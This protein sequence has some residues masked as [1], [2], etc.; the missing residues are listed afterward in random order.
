MS[1]EFAQAIPFR[2]SRRGDDGR[3][4]IVGRVFRE[5]QIEVVGELV[6]TPRESP[7]NDAA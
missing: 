5:G 2:R 1:S 3:T 6:V 4:R 7:N